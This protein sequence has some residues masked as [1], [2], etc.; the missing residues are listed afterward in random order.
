MSLRFR[1]SR[2]VPNPNV[3]QKTVK[4]TQ[5]GLATS[6]QFG[7]W[8]PMFARHVQATSGQAIGTGVVKKPQYLNNSE[9]R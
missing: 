1:W 6:A 5:V 8:Q 9:Y 2:L 3:V 4:T 7:K